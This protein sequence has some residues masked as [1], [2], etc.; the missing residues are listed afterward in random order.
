MPCP[1]FIFVRHG[2]AEH[3]V[4]AHGPE[5]DKAYEN[6]AYKDAPLT[7]EGIKQAKATAK[8]LA[9]LRILDIWSSPLTRAIQTAEEIFEETSAQELYLHDNL[10]EL[11]GGGHVCNER[12]LKGILKKLFPLWKTT[13]LPETPPFWV[14]RENEYSMHSR[15][16]MLVTLLADIYKDSP[17]DSYICIVSHWGAINSLTGKALGNAEFV[18]KSL[19][20]LRS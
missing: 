14:E 1:K 9:D 16:N 4:A 10:L 20:D 8:N 12:K 13:Y 5:G 2:Q 15:M 7:P 6:P 18:I 19:E 11:L 17:P 3:N